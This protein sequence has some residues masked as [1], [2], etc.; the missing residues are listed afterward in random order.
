MAAPYLVDAE[1]YKPALI[2]AVK[3]ATGRELV[4]EGPMKLSIFPVPRV[5]ARQVH[6][7]NA[8]GAKGAQMVDVRWVGA[9]PSWLALLKGRVEVGRLTLYQPVIVLETDANGVPNW[10]FKPGAGATQPAGA[11]AAG[12]HLAVG[13]LRIV[14]GTIS[15][16]NPQERPDVQG[17][18]DRRHGLGRFAGGPVLDC[19]QRHRERRAAVARLQA[20]ARPRADGH[21]TALSLKVLSGTLDFKGTVSEVGA[22]ADVK[23]HL[24]VSTGV[25]T[26]FIGAV[27]RASGQA[28]PNFDASVVGRFHLR[29]RHR[30]HRRRGLPSPTSRC[31][32]AATR[33]R[34]H[35]RWSRARRPRSPAM[36]PCPRSSSK[37]G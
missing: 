2:Q 16:T 18:A 21:A 7:A 25:L 26:D 33:R 22:N 12:L 4:I 20:W 15:Y 19:R 28:P 36:W 6:F 3:E 31:R 17:R 24:A 9:S 5:S 8:A 34:A 35:W 29:R 30:I 11:P 14:Q 1:A 32:W 37:N 27:V 23:G 13:E 10:Q